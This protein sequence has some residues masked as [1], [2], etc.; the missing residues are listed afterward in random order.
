LN[1]EGP[2]GHNLDILKG[3]HWL[4]SYSVLTLYTEPEE[5]M[6]ALQDIQICFNKMFVQ[7]KKSLKKKRSKEENLEENHNPVDVIV[8]ILLGFLAKPSAFLYNMAE[9]V[10]KVFCEGVTKSSLD[11][12]LDLISKQENAEE[13]LEAKDQSLIKIN[14]EDEE[15]SEEDM[16]NQDEMMEKFDSKLSE[17]FKNQKFGK[18]KKK[19]TK[20]QRIHYKHKVIGL[21]KIFVKEQQNNPLIFELIMPLLKIA[22]NAKT[23]EIAKGVYNLLNTRVVVIKDGLTEFDDSKILTLLEQVQDMARKAHFGD[24]MTLCWKSCAFLLKAIVRRHNKESSDASR[25]ITNQHIKKAIVVYESTYKSWCT[26]S[27]ALNIKCFSQLPANIPQIPWH[28]SELFLGCTDPK[29]AKNPKKVMNAYDVS[30]AICNVALPKKK[31]ES[32]GANSIIP[33]LAPKIRENLNNTLQFIAEDLKCGN[34]NFDSQAL[35]S[36]LKFAGLAIKRTSTELKKLWNTKKLL[37]LLEKIKELPRF[38][39]SQVINNLVKEITRNFQ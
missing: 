28:F 39:S 25:E 24:M 26:K 20:Y 17:F 27:S 10:F 4:F 23:D 8:D 7:S 29:T 19:D 12:M 36:I 21:L 33:K 34:Q 5:A 38:K 30:F 2:K 31:R 13:E 35:K 6:N 11:L 32:K 3:F 37:P 14:N 22:K 9:Q 15:Y 16:S 1:S 18:K